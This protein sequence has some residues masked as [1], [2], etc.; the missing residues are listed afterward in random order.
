SDLGQAQ[1]RV[2]A[3]AVDAVN[4]FRHERGVQAV[5]VGDDAGDE[6]ERHEPVGGGQRIVVF[7]VDFVLADGDLVVRRFDVEA[8]RVQRGDDVAPHV[9][10]ALDGT[11]VKVP[12]G[13]VGD[14]GRPSFRVAAEEEE[15]CLGASVHRE[16]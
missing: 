2:H 14:G 10:A 9:L 8:H 3:G 4:R 12:A 6:L 16:S 15:L 7:E 13:V 1:V 11:E 5:H